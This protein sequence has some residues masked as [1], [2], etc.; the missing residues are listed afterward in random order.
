VPDSAEAWRLGDDWRVIPGDRIWYLRRERP[1]DPWRLV[2]VVRSGPEGWRA[3]YRNFVDGLPRSIRLMSNEPRRF[4]L[5]LELAQVE[6]NVE[7]EP[8]T[9]RVTVPPGTQP[10][11][12]EE[13]RAGG[14]LS[15]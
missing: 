12:I 15:R 2:S 13:L 6:L 5:R 10:I 14:P 8:S 4:D 3:D 11:T 7:L 1:A 9:F